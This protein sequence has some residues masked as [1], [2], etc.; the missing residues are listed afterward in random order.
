M[1]KEELFL[2]ALSF[3]ML[4]LRSDAELRDA[5]VGCKNTSM[6]E[7]SFSSGATYEMQEM[8]LKRESFISSSDEDPP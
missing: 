2:N 8:S 3:C 6:R 1:S 5:F 4:L 7:L